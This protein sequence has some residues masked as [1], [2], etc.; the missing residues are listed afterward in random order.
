MVKELKFRRRLQ[1]IQNGTACIVNVPP[2]IVKSLLEDCRD[3]EFVVRGGN[4]CLLPVAE[5]DQDG[6]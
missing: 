6:N 3:V 5:D 4:V 1:R 2:E